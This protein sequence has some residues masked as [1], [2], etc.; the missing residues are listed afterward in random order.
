MMTVHLSLLISSAIRQ[1]AS[2]H[3][4]ISFLASNANLTAKPDFKL[5]WHWCLQDLQAEVPKVPST[6]SRKPN[7]CLN[8]SPVSRVPGWFSQV[9]VNSWYFWLFASN[10]HENRMSLRILHLRTSLNTE[11]ATERNAMK[12]VRA[13]RMNPTF[14]SSHRQKD[15]ELH[16][17]KWCLHGA[18][19][20]IKSWA[21]DLYPTG[22]VMTV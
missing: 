1:F 20:T 18:G 10:L 2:S 9:K 21:R 6:S 11:Y 16:D 13:K 4:M 19:M 5:Q 17:V 8:H 7:L 3:C 14:Y 12:T 22:T 15:Y